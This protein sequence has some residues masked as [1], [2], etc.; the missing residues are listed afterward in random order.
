MWRF[1]LVEDEAVWNTMLAQHPDASAGKWARFRFWRNY[2]EQRELYV[3]ASRVC[4]RFGWRPQEAP[5]L[6]HA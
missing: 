4:W 2:I 1:D 3:E 6:F 5:V